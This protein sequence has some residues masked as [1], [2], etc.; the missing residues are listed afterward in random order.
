M[1]GM[2]A[3]RPHDGPAFAADDECASNKTP[4]GLNDAAKNRIRQMVTKIISW[5]RLRGRFFPADLFSDPV[6]D[7]L[8]DLVI[9][10]LD[11]RPLQVSYIGI[12]AGVPSSTSLRWIRSLRAQGF[13]RRWQDPADRRRELVELSDAGFQAFASYIDEIAGHGE[14]L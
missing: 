9:A 7:M 13:V 1:L 2:V 4:D 6:W 10:R 3:D 8:L 5:R 14:I 12:E 11:D